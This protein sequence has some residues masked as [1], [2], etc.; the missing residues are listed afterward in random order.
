MIFF[1]IAYAYLE[2]FSILSLWKPLKRGKIIRELTGNS[3]LIMK[4]EDE[5]DGSIKKP[6][7]FNFSPNP[8][9][10]KAIVLNNIFCILPLKCQR[11][12]K[13]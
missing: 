11:K 4:K 7:K 5:Y 10:Y 2:K 8:K 3:E 6:V 9:H 1:W 13:V 12:R